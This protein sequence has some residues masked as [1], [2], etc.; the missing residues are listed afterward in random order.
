MQVNADVRGKLYDAVLAAIAENG[1][2]VV[3]DAYSGGGC[4]PRCLRRR[5]GA[6][7]G[8]SWKRRPCA[9]RTN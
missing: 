1:D 3:V 5:A 8:S 7:T 9:V 6:F 2:E 4:S